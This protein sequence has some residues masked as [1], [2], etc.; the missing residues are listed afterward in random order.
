[1]MQRILARLAASGGTSGGERLLAI[2]GIVL[3]AATSLFA[4]TMIATR[5]G[6]TDLPHDFPAP[7]AGFG[8]AVPPR[9]DYTPTGTLPA[10]TPREALANSIFVIAYRLR[11]TDGR[12]AI[13]EGPPGRI[14]TVGPGDV[15]PTAGRVVAIERDENG[16]VLVTTQR[17]IE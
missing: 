16:W 3:A 6:R 5:S 13:V 1:M 4:G 7:I 14:V 15:L 17:R 12:A 11:S 10:A 9:L 2:G 8:R